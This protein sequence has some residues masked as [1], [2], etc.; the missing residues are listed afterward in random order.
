MEK[1]NLFPRIKVSILE[2]MRA[3]DEQIL[4]KTAKQQ[5]RPLWVVERHFWVTQ[6]ILA[7]RNQGF[8][9][10]YKGGTSLGMIQNLIPRMAHDVD[11]QIEPPPDYLDEVP[12]GRGHN[13]K[14]DI[15][16]R[17]AYFHYLAEVLQFPEWKG[18]FSGVIDPKARNARIAYSYRAQCS[19]PVPPVINLELGFAR[20]DPW[21]EIPLKDPLSGEELGAVG[22]YDPYFN[23]LEKINIVC[24]K[25]DMLVRNHSW[26]GNFVH[27]YF[28][29]YHLLKRK[30][31]RR[32]LLTSVAQGYL[33]ELFKDRYP[34]ALTKNPAFLPWPKELLPKAEKYWKENRPWFIGEAA[35]F[36]HTL[37]Q[38]IILL[39]KEP[40]E[41]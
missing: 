41:V 16:K 36:S 21:V 19:G 5:N 37:A 30:D 7:I 23:F 26:P 34:L 22:C 24:H 1:V 2:G 35:S 40:E 28:D 4:L 20:T 12:W 17:K 10:I 29:L 8:L 6:L 38:V 33:Q 31:F 27:Q 3:P 18:T 13:H 11:V 9:A 14:K 25:Y 15:V 39:Q 32:F